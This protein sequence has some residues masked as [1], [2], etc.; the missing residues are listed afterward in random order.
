ME[1]ETSAVPTAEQLEALA[2]KLRVHEKSLEMVTEEEQSPQMEAMKAHSEAMD[3][4]KDDEGDD[5]E[6]EKALE[7]FHK[8][9][10]KELQEYVAKKKARV[11]GK[12]QYEKAIL[13]RSSEYDAV[14]EAAIAR[15]APKI[16][17]AIAVAVEKAQAPISALEKG[18]AGQAVLAGQVAKTLDNLLERTFVV[19]SAPAPRKTVAGLDAPA[20]E[21]SLAAPQINIKPLEN[22]ARGEGYANPGVA[23]PGTRVNLFNA[24]EKSISNPGALNAV[25][26]RF[27]VP[28]EIITEMGVK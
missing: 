15:L 25:L 7:D 28:A 2:A 24:V 11:G 26:D 9:M 16:E 23:D 27:G 10:P 20:V 5:E 19:G 12:T 18:I 1:T 13:D 17:A 3:D 4:K 14:V 21:K 6:M 8:A 22:W